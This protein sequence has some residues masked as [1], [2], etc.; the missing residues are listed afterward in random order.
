MRILVISDIHAN[1]TALEAVIAA[2]A[3]VDAVWCLG[4]LVGYGPDPNECVERVRSLPNLT[5]LMG[6][7]DAAV[8]DAME[9]E[10]FNHDAAAAIGWTKSVLTH[11]NF[12]FLRNLPQ[13]R[14]ST[15]FT[16]VHASPQNPVWEYLLDSYTAMVNF[17]CFTSQIAI[18]GHTHLPIAFSEVGESKQ[19]KRE[20]LK[21]GE[22]VK[23]NTRKILNPGSVG[24]PRDHDPRASFAILDPEHM[25]W[26]I[27][28]VEYNVKAVQER[29]LAAGLPQK[30]ALRLEEGW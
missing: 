21:A 24:Q 30:H 18:V 4:D 13:K 19:V 25:T 22:Q 16:L 3:M 11:E 28:R 6:N 27:R 29:I 14:I 1:F 23:L 9:L 12:E 5:C 10:M 20:M 15:L 26:R 2:N 17:A 8:T 7:H